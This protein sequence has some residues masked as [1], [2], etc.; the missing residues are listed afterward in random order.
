M[1][2]QGRN[3]FIEMRGADVA[4]LQS[5]AWALPTANQ[6]PSIDRNEAMFTGREI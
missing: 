5:V 3:L 4:L 2:L 1:Q 6:T